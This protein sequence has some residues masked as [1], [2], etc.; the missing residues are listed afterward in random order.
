M[1]CLLLNDV[2][3]KNKKVFVF[4]LISFLVCSYLSG[5]V[6]ATNTVY[7]YSVDGTCTITNVTA[8]TSSSGS[9]E[10]Y[11]AYNSWDTLSFY[12]APPSGYLFSYWG[13]LNLYTTEYN[14][15]Y[16]NPVSLVVTDPLYLTAFFVQG[17]TANASGNVAGGIYTILDSTSGLDDSGIDSAS[18]TF[19]SGD[20]VTFSVVAPTGYAFTYWQD[21]SGNKYYSSSV[22]LNPSSNL[23]MTAYFSSTTPPTPSSYQYE[24]TGPFY[25]DGSVATGTVECLIMWVNGSLYN[26]NLTGD[27]VTTQT[28]YINSTT[29]AYQI[30]WVASSIYNYSRI[31][32]L[33]P[34]Y[35]AL[36]IYI[37]D[38]DK[39][40]FLYSF[41]VIDFG[42]NT[43]AF[44]QTSIS[45]NGT[46][47]YVVERLNLNATNTPTFVMQQYTTYTLSFICDQGVYVQTFTAMQTFSNNFIVPASVFPSSDVAFPTVTIDR[48]NSMMI[49]I[50][51]VDS[52]NSTSNVSII[53]EHDDITDYTLEL[54]YNNIDILWNEAE[55]VMN[56]YVSVT[57]VINGTEY[58]WVLPA[59][60][61]DVSNP[62]LGV[63]DF[64][65]INIDTLP[66]I[67]MGWPDGIGSSQIA[68][69]V[70]AIII[71]VMLGI[72]SYRNAGASCVMAWIMGGVM[73]AIGWWNGGLA[74][75]GVSAIPEFALALFLSIVVAIHEGKTA[76]GGLS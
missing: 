68:Q 1:R 47:N 21:G 58:L 67:Y 6:S 30:Q 76:G 17:Y 41:D 20:T 51:Y 66:N 18:L 9:G 39:P 56:Y 45:T 36:N 65:G 22:T 33:F 25:D 12:V 8:S 57:A 46:D 19:A 60:Y 71:T 34:E 42:A 59:S 64:L 62:W 52:S 73:F 50:I 15:Y 40:F 32:D 11:L 2:K 38:P 3:G 4:L 35:E 53:I 5:F 16:T 72:G 28:E 24:I 7:A 55:E 74:Q 70:A 14:N 43:N 54:S 27:G 49:E 37:P 23:V 26:F 13:A 29:F 44:L 48:L 75:S 61:A 31:I 63:F 69:F 10:I